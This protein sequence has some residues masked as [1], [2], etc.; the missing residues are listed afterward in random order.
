MDKMEE[1]RND[2]IAIEIVNKFIIKSLYHIRY[3]L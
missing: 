3:F 1:K 2:S